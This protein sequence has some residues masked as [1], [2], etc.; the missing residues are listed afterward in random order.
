MRGG[1]TFVVWHLDRLAR[2]IKPLLKTVEE[3]GV[4]DRIP[5]VHRSDRH[6]HLRRPPGLPHL[7]GLG[8][9]RAGHHS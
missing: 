9:V 6:H 2:S 3:L 8:R 1:D 7:C 5:V 4:G